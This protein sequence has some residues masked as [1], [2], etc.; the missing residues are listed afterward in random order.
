MAVQVKADGFTLI[1]DA[2]RR[3][4]GRCFENDERP[5]AGP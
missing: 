4:L 5:K 3:E 2:Y 1:A